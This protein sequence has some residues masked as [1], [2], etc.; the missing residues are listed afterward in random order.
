MVVNGCKWL[1][2]TG[3][4]KHGWKCL[5]RFATTGLAEVN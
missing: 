5:K 2:M 1:N 3:M 4:A